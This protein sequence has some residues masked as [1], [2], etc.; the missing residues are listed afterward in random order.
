MNNHRHTYN[1]EYIINYN[2]SQQNQL[3]YYKDIK[4]C[5]KCDFIDIKFHAS[6]FNSK[7]TQK[8]IKQLNIDLSLIKHNHEFKKYK[9]KNHN[10]D[11]LKFKKLINILVN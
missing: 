10:V 5:I 2:K 8:L 9:I 3:L 11:E 1:H 4:K 6:N 7:S